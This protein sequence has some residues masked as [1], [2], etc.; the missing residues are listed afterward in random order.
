MPRHSIANPEYQSD[1]VD[2]G[3]RFLA[4]SPKAYLLEPCAGQGAPEWFP[5]LLA[6]L[7]EAHRDGNHTLT[8]PEW[9]FRNKGWL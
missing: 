2:R 9:L 6:E 7:S 8:A 5:R 4:E 1:L 3:V